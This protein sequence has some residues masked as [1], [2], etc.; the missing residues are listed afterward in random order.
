MSEFITEIFA[1]FSAWNWPEIL[2]IC[3]SAWMAYIATCALQNWKRQSKAQKETEF[4][5]KLTDAV[6]EFIAL[7]ATPVE[8]VGYIKIRIESHADKS[9]TDS[10]RVNPGVRTYIQKHGEE[11]VKKLYE[12]LRPC[13]LV[14]SKVQSLVAK[15]QVFGLKNYPGCQKSCDLITAQHEKIQAFCAIIGSPSWNWDNPEV[16]AVLSKV[17]QISADDLKKQLQDQNVKFLAF[18]KESYRA[19]YR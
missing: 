14:L 4:L 2:K 6:H 19:T 15:G 10:D 7:I 17:L 13:T 12:Y 9:Q 8:M 5:D 11:D 1:T 18:V 3:I 16:L